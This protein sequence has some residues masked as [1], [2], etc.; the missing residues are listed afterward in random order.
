LER[1]IN[2]IV[3]KPVSLNWKEAQEL[4]LLAKKKKVVILPGYNYLFDR[5]I[6]KA[7]EI[8]ESGDLGQIFMVKARQAHNWGGGEPFSWSLK[9]ELSGGGTIIDNASH[10]LNLFEHLFGK[11]E[12]LQVFT[13]N[14]SFKT[15]VEENTIINTKFKSGLIGTVETSWGDAGG[16]NNNLMIFGKKGNLEIS[17]CNDRK[18]FEFKRYISLPNE[19]NQEERLSYYI[20]KGVEQLAKNIN[21]DNAGKLNAENTALLIDNFVNQ[22]KSDKF[23]DYYMKLAVRTLKLIFACYESVKKEKVITVHE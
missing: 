6:N 14:L 4:L 2:V 19:W 11:I 8:I 23:D 5:D 12:K 15:G 20:P 10:L 16:R 21:I 9:P 3:E 7:R 22:V 17:E 1:N 13:N 18:V